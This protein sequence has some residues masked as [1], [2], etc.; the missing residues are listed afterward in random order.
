MTFL[1]GELLAFLGALA[2]PILVHLLNLRR[3]RPREIPTLR[4]LKEIE[5]TRLKR[6]KLTRWLLLLARLLLLAALVLAFARP[7]LKGAGLLPGR[8]EPLSLALL[9][10]DSASSRLPSEG[11]ATV[12]D[13]QRELAA[14]RLERLEPRDRVWLVPLSRPALSAGPLAPDA[15]RAHLAALRP[16]WGAAHPDEALERALRA[17]EDAPA[18]H[19]QLLLL[20]D[21]RLA[22][23]RGW[24]GRLPSDL[25][26]G[27]ALLPSEAGA[28]PQA[29][30]L[31]S[32]LLREDRPVALE[33]LF[34][35]E[36]EIGGLGFSLAL[37]GETRVQR[38]LAGGGAGAWR[39]G[40]EL[41]F[42][43]PETGWLRGELA[44]AGDAVEL[45]NSLPFVLHVPARRRV[46][47][48]CGD[49][50]LARVLAAALQPDERYRRGLELRRLDAGGL[51]AL[52]PG[53]VDQVVLALGEA[54]GEGGLRRLREL[55]ARGVRFLLLP[56]ADCDAALAE[57]QLRELGLPSAAGLRAARG[58][59]RVERLDRGHE[60]IASILE[61]DRPAE[62]L[63]VRRLLE[64]GGPPA[65]A[66]ART[67]AQAGG[68][69]LV[70]ALERDEGRALILASAPLE[71]WSDLAMSGL[72]A[73]LLQ[74]GLRW[75]DGDERLPADQVCGEEGRWTP[76]RG[77]AGRDWRLRRGEAQ[78]RLE[79]D[80]VKGW[81][82]VPPLPEPGHY[83]VTVDGRPAGWL[84]ARLPEGETV[85]AEA[86]AGAWAAPDAGGWRYLS[87]REV[88]GG[89]GAR[90]LG[91]LL[92]GLAMALLA[93]E[94]WLA[95]GRGSA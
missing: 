12:W 20:S 66:R 68:L 16:G 90:D 24:A 57:R 11:G 78:W 75:L 37:E 53:G 7:V 44:L 21:G 42:R 32:G 86:P 9:L 69:P 55:A 92:L 85:R 84:A 2:L 14:A 74:Q 87:A 47:L 71:A 51:A 63:E 17:L 61:P 80:P 6:V 93:L 58:A 48:A 35:G 34:A 13:R 19:R 8:R 15:A 10:D 59:W 30:S 43:L 82:G 76:P 81:L 38:A 91:P 52:D 23:P 49:E 4:F 46:A 83:Q 65:G 95:A 1:G 62:E 33:A 22:P 25:E 77:E 5:S 54:G 27:L 70:L 39:A 60:I 88:E 28:A 72:L 50:G 18:I 89:G 79:L 73:P 64:L 41:E 3:R 56:A 29:L 45:D 40:E 94:T 67:L 26:R 31:R 36:G